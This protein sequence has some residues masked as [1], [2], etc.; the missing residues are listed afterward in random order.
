MNLATFW[1]NPRKKYRFILKSGADFVIEARKI[2]IRYKSDT[3]VVTQWEV[4]GVKGPLPE[5]CCPTEIV[6]II[7]L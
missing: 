6:A 2:N 5:Y 1:K 7:R 4:E 3:G